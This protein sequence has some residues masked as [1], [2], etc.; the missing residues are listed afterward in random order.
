M[1]IRIRELQEMTGLPKSSIYRLVREGRFPRPVK[2]GQ[3]ASGWRK[4]EIDQW[5]ASRSA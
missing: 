5:A 2:L 4:S 1:F 3:R